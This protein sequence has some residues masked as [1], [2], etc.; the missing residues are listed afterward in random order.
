[1]GV[2]VGH[3]LRAKWCAWAEC[4]ILTPH[5]ARY[6]VPD[7]VPFAPD[8][9]TLARAQATPI[10]TLH[11]GPERAAVT[12]AELDATSIIENELAALRSAPVSAP[13]PITLTLPIT[14]DNGLALVGYQVRGDRVKPGQTVEVLTYWQVT[15]RITPPLTIFV[16]LLDRAGEI[17]GQHD[18]LGAAM[19]MLEPGDVIIQRHPITVNAEAAPGTY[20][21]QVG[22][23][24]P[25]SLKRFQA[26]PQGSS[27]VD[28]ILLSTLEVTAP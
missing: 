12:V 26:Q 23:Y 6:I 9:A 21:L 16:H 15:E 17:R 8:V 1:L 2:R 11:L 22:L 24:H 18:G 14:F 4:F 20:R 13:G 3:P 25:G 10:K 7:W 5:P 19:T 28:R 27:P